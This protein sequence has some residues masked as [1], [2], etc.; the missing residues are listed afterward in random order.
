MLLR[1]R[2]REL[3]GTALLSCRKAI[4]ERV[5]VLL[6]VSAPS[7]APGDK[8]PPVCTRTGALIV[9]LPASVAPLVT[10]T[11]AGE[12][13]PLTC[14]VPVPRAVRLETPVITPLSDARPWLFRVR[15]PFEGLLTVPNATVPEFNV[16]AV[17]NVTGP[18]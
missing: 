3:V 9:P 2:T 11:D 10:V 1:P 7:E 5:S 8:V 16:V 14:T 13:V 4:P 17:P 6:I 15:L 12:I 18:L